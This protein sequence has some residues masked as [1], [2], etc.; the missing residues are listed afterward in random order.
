MIVLIAFDGDEISLGASAMPLQ[1]YMR[2]VSVDDH[3]IEPADVW[4]SRVPAKYGD[5]VPHVEERD[6]EQGV[7]LGRNAHGLHQ[8]WMYEG[9]MYAD[10]GLNAVAGK[11][12]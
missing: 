8:V 10:I 11:D 6:F 12:P 4:T 1:D 7:Q 5:A 9:E 2:L 3:A